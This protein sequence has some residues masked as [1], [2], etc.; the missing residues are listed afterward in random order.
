MRSERYHIPVL[1]EESLAGLNIRPDGIYVDLTFGGGGHSREILK[2]IDKGVLIGFDQDPD[3]GKNAIVD[4]RFHFV[5]HNY[6]YFT[7]H[8]EYMGIDRVDGILAD[9]GVSSFQLDRPEKGFSYRQDA[10]LDMRM[11]PD[12][13]RS[14]AD[15]IASLDEEALARLL[16]NFGELPNAR[17]LARRLA[18]HQ[19]INPIKT[20]GELTEAVAGVI[21]V[22][23]RN[24]ILSQVF[25]AF[26]I[27]VNQEIESLREMLQQV[28]G[29]LR[30]GG[31]VAIISY[32][33]L[34][35]RLV[36]NF[37]RSGDFTG[38]T[39]SDLYGQVRVPLVAVNRQSITPGD[40]ELVL[41][42]RA[43]SARLRI[44]ERSAW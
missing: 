28:P 23:K 37:I 19:K 13:P 39:V 30:E 34:E 16:K 25:Q 20:T 5:R 12:M 10:P 14:A 35:D 44:A 27:A 41:N 2:R 33:S 4:P 3:A 36:K 21:P 18:V 38:Q 15:L 11:N 26:R 31:R 7:N 24:K 40:E 29:M 6:R 8:L 1:L 17:I 43:R 9:L 42:P 22:Q 32:H